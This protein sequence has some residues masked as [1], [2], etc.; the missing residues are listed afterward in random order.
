MSL[1]PTSQVMFASH[2]HESLIC[3]YFWDSYFLSYGEFKMREIKLRVQVLRR[4]ANGPCHWSEGYVGVSLQE[5]RATM[6]VMLGVSLRARWDATLVVPTICDYFFNFQFLTLN[7]R[8]CIYRAHLTDTAFARKLRKCQFRQRV[9]E[10]ER[11]RW[12]P[13]TKKS[14]GLWRR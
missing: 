10:P 2:S 14:F 11:R 1:S 6:Q 8:M 12:T 3:S 13:N 9:F 7:A 4:L 5:R